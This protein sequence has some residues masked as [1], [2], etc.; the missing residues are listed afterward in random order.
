MAGGACMGC[1][2]SV[3]FF[4]MI[5]EIPVKSGRLYAFFFFICFRSLLRRVW[6]SISYFASVP[7]RK[8]YRGLEYQCSFVRLYLFL[9]AFLIICIKTFGFRRLFWNTWLYFICLLQYEYF[10]VYSVHLFCTRWSFAINLFSN[11]LVPSIRLIL[12][13]RTY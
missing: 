5:K 7:L 6:F 2:S 11:V 3:R 9:F 13:T 12:K 1:I 8:S 4:S 10:A